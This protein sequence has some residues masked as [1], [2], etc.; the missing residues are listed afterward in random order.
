VDFA[1]RLRNEEFALSDE[2]EGELKAYCRDA[3]QAAIG[4]ARIGEMR[5]YV[6]ILAAS[7]VRLKIAKP[8]DFGT[9]NDELD[10]L[11]E[12]EQASAEVQELLVLIQEVMT[13][14]LHNLHPLLKLKA[15]LEANRPG[16]LRHQEKSGEQIFQELVEE[17]M[18]LMIDHIKE[19]RDPGFMEMIV[20]DMRQFGLEPSIG[21]YIQKQLLQ[22]IH[23]LYEGSK[24]V[25]EIRP[26][27][28]SLRLLGL[29]SQLNEL[30]RVVTND[31]L[32]RAFDD[33][34]GDV[35]VR[36]EKLGEDLRVL[37]LN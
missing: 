18:R 22:D 6:A 10:G 9:S 8:G 37:G 2:K 21:R 36:I 23:D 5:S 11:H 4:K 25:D 20:E 33:P 3:L 31:H 32:S 16:T 17:R 24:S 1:E 28:E 7:A 29:D 30:A 15:H 13:S 35:G 26:F 27:V 14:G 19:G 34:S 12:A